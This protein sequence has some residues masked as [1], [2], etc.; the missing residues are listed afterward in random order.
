MPKSMRMLGLVVVCLLLA[1]PTYDPAPAA[2]TDGGEPG[3]LP[4]GAPC[5]SWNQCLTQA[6]ISG[7]CVPQ[8]TS[9]SSSAGGA[10]ATSSSGAPATC[11]DGGGCPVGQV[12]NGQG[13]CR[14]PGSACVVRADCGATELCDPISRHCAA[15]VACDALQGCGPGLV[16]NAAGTCQLSGE[17]CFPDGSG[18]GLTE[19]CHKATLRC[20]P[21]NGAC[22]VTTDCGGEQVCQGG[23]CITLQR[24]GGDAGTCP[25]GLRCNL[26]TG[27]CQQPRSPCAPDGSGC[28]EGELCLPPLYRC[29]PTPSCSAQEPTCPGGTVCST[30]RS[31]CQP[32]GQACSTTG[33]CGLG[34]ECNANVCTMPVCPPGCPAGLVCNAQ[35]GRCQPRRAA[36]GRHADCGA[37]EFCDVT[38]G[39]CVA[40]VCS[41]QAPECPAG[42]ECRVAE[43]LCQPFMAACTT[44]ADCVTGEQCLAGGICRRSCGGDAGY[45][46]I[47]QV[48]NPTYDLCQVVRSTCEDAAD[49]GVGETCHDDTGTCEQSCVTDDDCLPGYVCNDTSRCQPSGGPCAGASDCGRSEY[50]ESN[51]CSRPSCTDGLL[52]GT[53][54]DLDCGGLCPGCAVGK[55]CNSPLDCAPLLQCQNN[56]CSINRGPVLWFH[57]DDG[58]GAT[59]TDSS[60]AGNNGFLTGS[61]VP[62]WVAGWSGRA[63]EF[64]GGQV[65]VADHPSLRNPQLT[66]EA[67]VKQRSDVGGQQWLL[68][69]CYRRL[70]FDGYRQPHA[71]LYTSGAGETRVTGGAIPLAPD[72]WHHVALT[73]DGTQNRIF[74]DGEFVGSS[75]Q[76]PGDLY[77]QNY[78]LFIG[79]DP[80]DGYPLYGVIDEVRIY[81]YARTPEQV[82]EDATLLLHLRFDDGAGHVALDEAYNGNDALLTEGIFEPGVTGTA[83]RFDGTNTGEVR[84]NPGMMVMSRVTVEAWVRALPQTASVHLLSK[85]IDGTAATYGFTSQANSTGVVFFLTLDNVVVSSPEIAGALDGTWHHV[86]G[87][88]NG[89]EVEVYLDGMLYAITPATGALNTGEGNFRLGAGPDGVAGFNGLLDNVRVYNRYVAATDVRAHV[90]VP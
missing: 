52:N 85:A 12:C 1:C 72:L 87:S 23:L 82:R 35:L 64:A 19:V 3:T 29:E 25:A 36:C 40:L 13:L 73:W 88:Y 48:C 76:V 15:V 28:A 89:T 42:M 33:E 74:A 22:A 55:A 75:A 63:L 83:A 53:E 54:V 26:V 62:P 84:N 49:C 60:G 65:A 6:C 31:L 2:G 77:D 30:Q 70:G 39:T 80:C 67:W 56:V 58:I 32:T 18:C 21:P 71:V 81:N 46:P 24:C 8:G 11:G 41:A 38:S 78:A 90:L 51:R 10:S 16:C 9:T 34:E 17:A 59:A 66:V 50:C 47:G 37:G 43:G 14:P 45:C 27:V 86:A 44:S 4:V 79:R 57:F 5:S 20:V 7:F 69:K 68:G 61:P